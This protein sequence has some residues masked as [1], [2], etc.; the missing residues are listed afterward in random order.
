MPH[1]APGRFCARFQGFE[2]LDTTAV[3]GRVE[4]TDQRTMAAQITMTL[5]YGENYDPVV[6]DDFCRAH[7]DVDVIDPA[8]DPNIK[9]PGPDGRIE[10]ELMIP[11]DGTG[12][13]GEVGGGPVD[14][15]LCVEINPLNPN[16][17]TH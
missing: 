8:A 4:D 10:V 5:T 12:Q 7:I 13:T 6:T 11:R 1:P 14:D 2:R 15:P 17:R 3:L 9:Y 16:R